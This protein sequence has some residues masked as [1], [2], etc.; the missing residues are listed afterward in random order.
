M[1]PAEGIQVYLC[2]GAVDM[3]KSINGLSTLVEGALGLSPFEPALYVFRNR[4][5]D[6][7]KVLYWEGNGFV[8]WYKRY[9]KQRVYWPEPTAEGVTTVTGRE[10]NWLLDGY[11]LSKL[12]P[13][14][15]LS[16]ASVL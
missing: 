6:K 4:Q 13:N 1:R 14:R 7:V 10:L 16:Y 8:V 12:R 11:D 2:Q 3:R 5:R 15:K 9:E